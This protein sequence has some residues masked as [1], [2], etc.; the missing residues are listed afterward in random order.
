MQPLTLG[1][2]LAHYRLDSILGKGGM[3]VVYLAEDTQLHRRVA[4]K[5]LAPDRLDDSS[6]DRLRVEA[7]ILSS[8]SHPNVATVF[9]F[10]SE[11]DIDYLVM[12]FVP[13]VT[14]DALLRTAPFAT[15]RVVAL[16]FSAR[17]GSRGGA[18][19]GCGPP[20]HQARQPA[21]DARGV[22]E[23]SRLRCRDVTCDPRLR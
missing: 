14:M 1:G 3:G 21:C 7:L 23:D 8:L 22:P 15:E 9:D 4:L 18:C 6:R 11:R 16:G 13:G 19:G 10:G 2:T 17:P 20:R 12:E 5:V